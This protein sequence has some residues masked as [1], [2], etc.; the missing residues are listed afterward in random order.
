MAVKNS[1]IPVILDTDIGSDI[2]DTWALAMMLK[3]PELDVKLV[4]SDTGDTDYRARIIAKMLSV[5]ERADIPVGVGRQFEMIKSHQTQTRWVEGYRLSDYPGTIRED[6]VGAIIDVIMNSPTTVTLICIGPVPNIAEA[7]GREPRIVKNAR[8][9]G[10]HGSV[11]RGHGGSSRICAEYNVVSHTPECQKVFSAAWDMTMTPLDTCGMV[12][13]EGDDYRSVRLCDDP[14][15]RALMENYEVWLNASQS[16][17]DDVDR[18][19]TVLFDT[20]AV[21]LAFSEEL[22]VMENLG[23]RVSDEGYTLIDEN[24][25]RIRVATDWKDINA[26]KKLLMKRLTSKRV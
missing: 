5:A 1:R 15:V 20:V 21:Y 24:A 19:S 6:G 26:Y 16:P 8:F 14:L 18:K 7:L 11:R 22:L 3:S 12:V 25:K 2:D 9:V 13:L 10:M 4:V 23:I 17:P